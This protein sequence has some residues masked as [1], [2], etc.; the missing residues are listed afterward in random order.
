M[1]RSDNN[2]EQELVGL[3]RLLE[4]T[5]DGRNPHLD[6]DMGASRYIDNANTIKSCL[7]SGKIFDWGC[8]LGQMTYFLKNRGFDVVSYDVDQ[9]GRDFLAGIGQT[10][11]L[12][13]D[14]IKLPFADSSFDAV[15]SSG[16]LEHVPDPAASLKEVARI[17]K[18]D[19]YFFVFR[20]PNK[21]SYIEFISDIIGRGDHQVKYTKPEIVK[22]LK[23]N[24]Y[25]I[26]SLNYQGFLPYNLKGF[27]G[28]IRMGYHWLDPWWQKIDQLL[29][30][31]PMINKLSTNIE[32]VA[33]KIR[34]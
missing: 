13:T 23:E 19:G 22:L 7:P 15:L 10:L 2:R 12:A 17:T 34:K 21:Y 20:L 3:S 8:G 27:P 28:F 31:L 11:I 26:V 24:G 30:A 9:G 33:R 5:S 29:S 4:G 14:P 6:S 32:L 16:V 25:E 1:K 18:K